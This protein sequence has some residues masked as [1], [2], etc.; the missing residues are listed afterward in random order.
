[1]QLM[2][3]WE[4]R[5]GPEPLGRAHECIAERLR[6]WKS[7]QGL[8]DS[9]ENL[10]APWR[11]RRTNKSKM[12]MKTADESK[13]SSHNKRSGNSS[14]HV[15]ALLCFAVLLFLAS[16][17]GDQPAPPVD[18]P[19]PPVD[20]PI[21]EVPTQSPSPTPTAPV[22]PSPT[23]VPTPTTDPAPAAA[24]IAAHAAAGES[25]TRRDGEDGTMV[26]IQQ[27]FDTW[28]Q[29]LKDDDADLFHS[30][31]TREL[32]GSCGLGEL[33]SWLEQ[34]AEF[35]PDPVV[36]A[37]FL[38]VTDPTRA[39]AEVGAEQGAGQPEYSFSFPWPLALEDG[40][41]AGRIP[42]RLDH[43]YVPLHSIKPTLRAR[44]QGARIPADPWPGPKLKPRWD[45]HLSG[46]DDQPG[47]AG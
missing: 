4:Y 18:T 47:C 21:P 23:L 44:W 43:R 39:L 2:R 17:G 12:A 33:R 16:C 15:L 30:V 7:R 24:G 14:L 20:T 36:T 8:F 35:L 13:R 34:D 19:I 5:G 6:R 11:A 37:V 3:S 9:L 45:V 26:A 38:D 31:L 40:R 27:L 41:M 22:N 25:N 42:C 32:A 10:S 1:M 28:N 29:A 46:D